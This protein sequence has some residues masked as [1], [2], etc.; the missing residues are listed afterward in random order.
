MSLFSIPDFRRLLWVGF[1]ASTVRWLEMLAMALFVY[2]TTDSALVVVMLSMLRVLPMGL[3]GAFLGAA[4]DRFQQRSALILMVAVS[5]A[6]SLTLALL[7]SLAT[8]EVWHLMVASFVSGVCWAADN[9]VRR[10]MIGEA[11]GLDRMGQAISIDIGINNASRVLGPMLAGLL[12]AQHGMS[13][14]LWLGVSLYAL[15]LIAALGMGRRGSRAV[16]HQASFLTRL[17]EGLVW[18]R[19]DRRLIGVFL[20]TVIFNIFAW[21]CNS[22]IPV[23]ATGSLHL[24]PKD[25]GLLAGCEGVGGLIGALVFA[26]FARLEWYGPIYLGAVGVYLVTLI[27]FATVG[28]APAAAAIVL[29]NGMA[30]VGFAVMQATLVYR[31]APV[32]MRARLLG[33]LSAC[34]GT[35]PIGFMYLGF[36]ADLLTPQTA[37][38]AIAVQ[39][40]LAM[41]LTRRYWVA[42]YRP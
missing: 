2:R 12:F 9:P 25:V 36:L 31:G 38:A 3:F 35:G 27:G 24:G 34:I 15:S 40:L 14:V 23:I 8:L 6:C 33:V 42:V 19:G 22:M 20:V 32:E 18:L 11:V 28:F 4:A 29:L 41:L 26:R 5:M 39:G 37:T 1:V 30:G 7:A 16:A 13:S 21:P 10:M 17:R